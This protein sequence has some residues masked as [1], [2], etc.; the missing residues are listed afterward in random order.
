MEASD[1]DR[2]EQ[3]RGMHEIC[4]NRLANLDASGSGDSP[5]RAALERVRADIEEELGDLGTRPG[6]S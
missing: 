1:P 3:L 6:S 4:V 2:V 5:L